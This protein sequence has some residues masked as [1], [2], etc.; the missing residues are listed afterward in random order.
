MTS[1]LSIYDSEQYLFEIAQSFIRSRIVFSCFHL[2]LFDLLVDHSEGLTCD[3]LS[4]FLHLNYL[5][6]ESRCLIDVLDA[7]TSMKFLERDTSKRI[8]RL[9]SLTKEY[10]LPHQNLLSN[11]E[12]EFYPQMTQCHESKVDEHWK[13][14]IET[15]MF[16]RLEELIDLKPYERRSIDKVDENL[17]L[18]VLFRQDETLKTKL[19]RAF[20]VLPSH[21]KGLLILVLSDDEVTLA[22]NIFLNMISQPEIPDENW[23]KILKEI[24][25]ETVERLQSTRNDFAIVLAY[26]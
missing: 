7:L 4:K 23:Q 12:K 11:L 18:I 13:E 21:G 5:P 19:H 3:E 22:M 14:S 25:F 26:K 9:T 15:L 24:G 20:D 17:D 2:K 6:G 1:S 16:I 8:Y 10:F